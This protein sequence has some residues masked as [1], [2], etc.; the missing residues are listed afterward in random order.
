[1]KKALFAVLTVVMLAG[2]KNDS[3]VAAVPVVQDSALV[4]PGPELRAR[5]RLGTAEFAPVAETLRVAGRIDFDEQRLARIGATITGR[6][7]Q[8][9]ALV[10]QRVSKGEVLAR[11]N[12]SELSQ[13][14]LAYLKARSELEL[15]R[16]NAERARSLFEADMISAAEL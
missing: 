12:S 3:Q 1:M 7:T 10:G 14:Q 2:C 8:I 5:L 4:A 16:R 6:V 9:D 13:Q 11:L 15:H